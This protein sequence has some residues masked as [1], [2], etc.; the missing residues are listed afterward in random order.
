MI[1]FKWYWRCD[2]L[3]AHLYKKI[4]SSC[5]AHSD[6]SLIGKYIN[7]VTHPWLSNG[8][9]NMQTHLISLLSNSLVMHFLNYFT[10]IYMYMHHSTFYSL[11]S[12]R[13]PA[14]IIC[15][16]IFLVV[17]ALEL[18]SCGISWSTLSPLERIDP[19]LNHVNVNEPPRLHGVPGDR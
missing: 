7:Y 14:N 6:S 13:I 16:Y 15:V 17:R 4:C 8:P 3:M 1:S 10:S 9:Y 2:S 11:H 19:R 5:W 18:F 12:E